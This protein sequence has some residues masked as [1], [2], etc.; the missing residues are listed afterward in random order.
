MSKLPPQAARAA[1]ALCLGEHAPDLLLYS[2]TAL[3]GQIQRLR[4]I[5]QWGTWLER[6]TRSA[7]YAGRKRTAAKPVRCILQRFWTRRTA[8][9]SVAGAPWTGDGRRS[10][11]P[12]HP[13]PLAPAPGRSAPAAQQD[14]L[15]QHSGKLKQSSTHLSHAACS[16]L[17]MNPQSCAYLH[18]IWVHPQR[19]AAVLFSQVEFAFPQVVQRPVHPQHGQVRRQQQRLGVPLQRS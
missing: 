4:S 15:A 16:I 5:I 7:P 9:V 1:G 12:G 10:A 14:H 2:V 13:A 3:P 11:A 8:A 17:P 19:T 6:L 18:I